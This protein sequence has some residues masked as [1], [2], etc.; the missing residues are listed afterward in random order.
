MRTVQIYK[1][2]FLGEK[3]RK[4]TDGLDWNINACQTQ[5]THASQTGNL[6]HQHKPHSESPLHN[7]TL[8]D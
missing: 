3:N 1:V 8:S 7:S 2:T 5:I 6:G 4:N